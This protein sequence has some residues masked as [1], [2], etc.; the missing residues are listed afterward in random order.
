MKLLLNE[1]EITI[2]SCN[3][4]KFNKIVA[5]IEKLFANNSRIDLYSK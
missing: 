1:L 2:N 3:L 4:F 5:Q